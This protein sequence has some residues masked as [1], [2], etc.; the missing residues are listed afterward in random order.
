MEA[1]WLSCSTGDW[2]WSWDPFA[3]VSDSEA[4]LLGLVSVQ[5]WTDFLSRYSVETQPALQWK[6]ITKQNPAAGLF[7]S[8]LVTPRL[9]RP[10][11]LSYCF[12]FTFYEAQ[13]VL[14]KWFKIT[15]K[16]AKRFKNKWENGKI[17]YSIYVEAN[18]SLVLSRIFSSLDNVLIS[19]NVDKSVHSVWHRMH[20]WP[21][22]FLSQTHTAKTVGTAGCFHM[23]KLILYVYVIVHNSYVSLEEKTIEGGMKVFL[24][25]R[26]YYFWNE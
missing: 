17:C 2:S 26:Q 19:V 12:T 20:C 5:D 6:K 16:A 25:S 1:T 10:L 14:W 9:T 24:C 8:L 23:C 4:F 13:K 7:L 22:R 21:H 15:G 11:I 18:W 3:R